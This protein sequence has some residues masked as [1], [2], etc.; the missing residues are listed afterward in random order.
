[1][2]GD[3]LL[4]TP[5]WGGHDGLSVLARQ[6]AS[7]LHAITG[8]RL[9]VWTLVAHAHEAAHADEPIRVR[10]FGGRR[11][12]LG[13]GAL[14]AAFESRP[15]ALVTL[16]VNQLPVAAP[17]SLAG[18]PLVHVLVGIEAWTPLGGVR[19]AV[20]RRAARTL[21]ISS[22]TARQFAVANPDLAAADI[23]VVHPHTPRATPP[24]PSPVEGAGYALIVGRMA[25]EERYK[26]HDTLIEIW[27]S[28]RA[29][30]PG[31][32]LVC[33]GSGDDLPRL[34]ALVAQLGLGEAITLT[35]DVSPAA[36]S[37]L[38][39]DCAFLVMPSPREGFG[40]V[41]LEAMA[42]GR[43][44]IG[45]RGSAE[46][47]IVAGTTGSIVDDSR[48][49]LREAILELFGSPET[50]TAR[51][52]AGCVRARSAFSRERFVEQLRALLAEVL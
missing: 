13:R 15:R 28:I 37:A 4:L 23:A 32:R 39:R 8:G 33:A 26:G 44:C 10:D 52:A 1:M 48:D 14:K 24:G 49:A 35:G 46:E 50:R 9:Q 43:A 20:L 3:V 6:Y 51:G 7:A 45:G 29:R 17:L 36:L 16:H 22:F 38:Y 5:T 31:A 41:F 42:A 27:P 11:G 30:A 2:T 40:L 47:I 19:A 21:A 18:V 34:R 12:G 25:A